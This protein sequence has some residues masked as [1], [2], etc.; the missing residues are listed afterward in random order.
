MVEVAYHSHHMATLTDSYR[1]AISRVEVREGNHDI[2]FFSSVSGKVADKSK[3]GADYWVNNLVGEV[4]FAQS[5]RQLASHS[6]SDGASRTQTLIEIG[7]HAALA[8]P[9]NQILEAIDLP[10]ASSI[11]YLSVLVRKKDAMI[12]ALALAS[13]LFVSGYAIEL[14]VVNQNGQKQIPPLIDLPPYA[15]NHAKSYTAESRI[16][17]AYRNRQHPRRDLIGVF[18]IHSSA[19]EPRWRQIIRL[20]EIPWLKDH[21]IQSSIVYPAAGYLAMA[22][23]AAAQRA[24]MRKAGTIIEGY[25]FREVVIS[26]GLI[27]SETP[28][29]VEV[30]I[31]VKA[32]SESM[33]TPSNL[34]DEFCVSSVS[35]DD[36]WTEHCRGLIAVQ[37]PSK[38][39]NPVN[40][41]AQEGSNLAA[42]QALVEKFEDVCQTPWNAEEL[43]K[44]L[45]QIGMHYGPTF[46]NLEC[47]RWA[48]GY[49]VGNLT[50]P[51]TA[52]VMPMHY[53]Q[54][55]VVHPGTLDSIF[56]TYLPALAPN[57]GR[58][59]DAIVPVS[60][61]HM[62]IAHDLKAQPGN[63]LVSYTSASRKDYRFSSASMTVFEGQYTPGSKP[64]IRIGEMTL[65][66]LD[67]EESSERD[68]EVPPRAY[69]V[70]WAPDVDLLTQKQL[71]DL[72]S[73]QMAAMGTQG[74]SQEID[75]A[76]VQLLRGVVAEI[77]EQRS[78]EAGEYANDLRK[79][80]SAQVELYTAHDEDSGYSSPGEFSTTIAWVANALPKLLLGEMTAAD[81][82]QMYGLA[83]LAATPGLFRNNRSVAAYIQLLAHKKP[84]LAVLTVGPRSGPASLN[85]LSLL[86]ELGDGIA[87]FATFHHSDA[88]LNI[89]ESAI[90]RFP[91]WADS[92]GFRD[93][94]EEG[95]VPETTC[96]G[97]DNTYDVVIAF[98]ALCSSA[99]LTKTLS[100]TS[101]LL[102]YGGSIVLANHATTSP[103]A[104]L[105]WGPLP[106]L[107]SSQGDV[108]WPTCMAEVQ[109]I[110]HGMGYK[111]RVTLSEDVLIVQ[112]AT[113]EPE[114]EA[115][116]TV[117]VLIVA[118][119]ETAGV[120]LKQLR[121]LC[122][123][124]GSATDV[125]P[126][127]EA[128]PRPGQACIVLSELSRAVLV[129]PNPAE[130]ASLKHMAHTSAGFVWVTRGAG[131]D[132][133]ADPQA[134]LVQGLARTVR[135]EAGDGPIV[136]LD[137]ESVEGAAAAAHIA[138]V[139][140]RR[141]LE[142]V[143]DD[144]VELVERGGILH[145]PR[146]MEDPDA[147]EQLAGRVGAAKQGPRPVALD[148]VGAACLFAGT[149]GLLDTLHFAADER[150]QGPP[151]PGSVEM[152]VKAAGINFK[153][154]MMAMGQIPVD[155]LGCESSGTITAVGSA[156]EGLQVGDR[157]VCMGAGSFCTQLRLDA[158]LVHRIPDSLSLETAAAL[159]ITYV[160]AF[161]SVHNV[162]RLG[163]GETILVHAATGGLGQA[164]VELSQLV[165]A[166]VLVCRYLR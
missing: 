165:G 25:Q 99:Q 71:T 13:S 12:T 98:D 31:S 89:Q 61:E 145:V 53:E 19:L 30:V 159:P 92:I 161:H 21:K 51:D 111:A 113:E 166:V 60:I 115:K 62:F 153:D 77:S 34:W 79:L 85:L 32:Y 109:G 164:V 57:S 137:L 114:A 8:G 81:L 139:F 152:R 38:S 123:E 40:G 44:R 130:W 155:E 146:M 151:P 54:A 76:I 41:Q 80:V 149:P 69:N 163:P 59:Y 87:P 135:A 93:V 78:D 70:K 14:S 15:W 5:L 101:T 46:A 43:Y 136:T 96:R 66:S 132:T 148:K 158:R 18:D 156:V 58:M 37:S 28:G 160:T 147:T 117:D 162:A 9:I 16:S 72:C 10:A 24:L 141:V 4:K 134:A 6:D 75:R 42:H 106:S 121:S 7:P 50:I 100:V 126:F 116:K 133:C 11:D 29:E 64:V 52:T 20:S 94:M 103:L 104:T 95:G 73:A 124:M 122:E 138:H 3:L 68:G 2:T 102:T 125:V 86:S 119:Q 49:C 91:S 108:A 83:A 90:T 39:T 17:R 74:T 97:I 144:D 154:V 110:V 127:G 55:D 22:M 118:E 131:S 26:S 84:S 45:S 36:Q 1:S 105:L 67:R 63:R 120:D 65:A 88:E 157:V 143:A 142:A 82:T 47:L 23:E 112:R 33:R 56:Q 27:I 129:D 48:P 140:R 128:R 107:L 35:S 150:V